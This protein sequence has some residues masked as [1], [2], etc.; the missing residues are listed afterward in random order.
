MT[1]R[2]VAIIAASMAFGVVLDLG[3]AYL[4]LM[5]FDGPDFPY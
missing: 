4:W 1:R 3:L 2:V 5:H